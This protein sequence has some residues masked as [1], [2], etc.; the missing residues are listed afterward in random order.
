MDRPKTEAAG[1]LVVIDDEPAV[2]ETIAMVLS[3]AGYAFAVT[4][5]PTE[6][7][8]LVR[9][10]TPDL[11][12]C[13]IAMPGMDGYAVLRAL[14]ADPATAGCPVAFLSAHREFT[15][16]VRAFKF[17]V[18]DYLAKPFTAEVL[19]RKIDR[20]LSGR[21]RRGGVA[22]VG[23]ATA[24][25]V[26][27]EE[28]QR[29]A[30]SGILSVKGEAGEAQVV[31]SQGAVVEKTAPVVQGPQ[32]TAEFHELD[33]SRETIATPDARDAKGAA[34]LP[35]FEDVHE[36]LR[37]ALVVD[38]D[39]VF[40]SFLV[41]VLKGQGFTVHEAG[42]GEEG[43]RVALQRQPWIILAD[44]RMPGV[45]GFE[46]CKRV[47]SH[48]LLRHTPFVFLS[49][50]DD[51]KNRY[52]GLEL[53]GD[54]YLPKLMPV[55]ELLMRIHLLLRRHSE[56]GGHVQGSS[57]KGMQ[58]RVDLVGTP[59]LLQ[60]CNLGRMTGLLTVRSGQREIVVRFREGQIIGAERGA[61][62]GREALH[63]L[64]SWTR[65]LFEF[66]AGDP[67]VGEPLDGQPFEQLL[68]EGCRR[69][70]EAGRGGES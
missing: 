14:Q 69:L 58:G 12:L 21:S 50:W 23:G 36:L 1:K 68:L 51:Y 62:R 66:A 38:D 2:C 61:T 26:L 22:Q 27:L 39:P 59:G 55:R 5:D 10:E 46:F 48:S 4:S 43:V 42:D 7:V 52:K 17:G 44:V 56:M 32:T 33:P 20:F 70:D 28:A 25:D 60:I 34:D 19:L 47:R 6:A 30:R 45:D 65:G 16:R 49:G 67:G 3:G 63:E 37:S 35:S 15:E 40:R 57:G 11:V 18:V 8:D 64:L 41:K 13:D 53:G 9:R 31:V 54:E 24:A 29:H